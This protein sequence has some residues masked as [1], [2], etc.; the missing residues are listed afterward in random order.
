MKKYIYPFIILGLFLSLISNH[1]LWSEKLKSEQERV[2]LIQQQASK[3]ETSVGSIKIPLKR[4]TEELILNDIDPTFL[5]QID[6]NF[7]LE[8]IYSELKHISSVVMEHRGEMLLV[9]KKEVKIIKANNSATL[10]D[11]DNQFLKKQLEPSE[12]AVNE[13]QRSLAIL[14]ELSVRDDFQIPKKYEDSYSLAI[15]ASNQALRY[16]NAEIK[17]LTEDYPYDNVIRNKN[18]FMLDYNIAI[19]ELNNEYKKV[20]FFD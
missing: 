4:D 7:L 17:Y 1:F 12:K 9:E 20:I 5:K 18:V 13:V 14:K 19:E 15:E 6:S 11:V 10:S 16:L 8:T 3:Q 2:F